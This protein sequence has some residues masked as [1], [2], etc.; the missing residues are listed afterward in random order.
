MF[1]Y[2]KDGPRV[3]VVGVDGSASSYRAAAYAAGLAR[4][5]AARLVFVFAT[6]A[7]SGLVSMTPASALG[8]AEAHDQIEAD[9]RSQAR[10]LDGLGVEYEIL[11]RR[12]DPYRE[13]IAVA[14]KLH[15]D[16]IVVGASATLGHRIVG[17]LAVHLIRAG[18]WPVTVVP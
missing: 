8:I 1:E 4:R 9:L 5:Q 6:P 15:A 2:G 14:D 18:R 16:A 3:V 11:R 12:G 7:P 17:S 10:R 13:I